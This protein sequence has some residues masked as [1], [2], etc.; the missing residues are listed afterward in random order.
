VTVPDN[1]PMAAVDSPPGSTMSRRAVLR[2]ITTSGALAASPLLL[3]FTKVSTR[4]LSTRTV[5]ASSG[6]LIMVLRHGEKPDKSRAPTAGIDLR[7]RPDLHSLTARGWTRAD[8]LV[9][10]FTRSDNVRPALP[11]PRVIYASGSGNGAGEGSRPRETVG[12]LAA[13]L[14]VPVN[15]IFSRGQ[16]TELA[17]DAVRQPGPVLIC[18]QH[19]S[20][21]A[22][23]AAL[24]P[25]T[26]APPTAWPDDRY[27][28]VWTFATADTGWHFAQIPELLL[29]GDSPTGLG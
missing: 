13:A 2:A 16:E 25:A 11:S 10:L 21:P 26:P 4:P 24:H 22:I 18:W 12:P 8:Y 7:G 5:D 28:V 14:D 17:Y 27:D 9:D 1:R 15:T 3:G 23:A 29:P 6:A 19:E 20:I